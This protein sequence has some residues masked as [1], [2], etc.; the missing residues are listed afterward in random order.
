MGG[1]QTRLHDILDRLVDCAMTHF[2]HEERLMRECGYPR[3]QSHMAEHEE[4]RRRAMGWQAMPDVVAAR[5]LLQFLKNWW[6]SHIQD[7]DKRIS[8]FIVKPGQTTREGMSV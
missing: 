4:M 8:P 2:E 6:T 1:D 3:L 7:E 5:E